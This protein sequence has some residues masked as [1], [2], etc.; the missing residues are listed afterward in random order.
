MDY[1]FFASMFGVA[2]RYNGTAAFINNASPAN[3]TLVFTTIDIVFLFF[4][5]L[6]GFAIIFWTIHLVCCK[7]RRDPSVMAAAQD[8]HQPPV[9][10]T[11]PVS[12]VRPGLIQPQHVNAYHVGNPSSIIGPPVTIDAHAV[13]TSR[14]RP[15][16]TRSEVRRPVHTPQLTREDELQRQKDLMILVEM[17]YPF[18]R[19][20]DALDQCNWDIDRALLC[21]SRSG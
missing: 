6:L 14:P 9:P 5:S 11:A 7:T 4:A 3:T 21:L 12:Y 10:V 16:P 2:V 20:E 8:H 18:A 15:S 19:A 13:S 1:P 17:G